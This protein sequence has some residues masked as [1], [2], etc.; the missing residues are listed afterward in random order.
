MTLNRE[1]RDMSE[2]SR[3]MGGGLFLETLQGSDRG[4]E[5]DLF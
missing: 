5:N 4:G 1:R 2:V 3:A